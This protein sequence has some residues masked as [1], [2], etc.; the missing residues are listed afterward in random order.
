[1]MLSTSSALTIAPL[2]QCVER[3]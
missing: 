2:K 1:M 3:K